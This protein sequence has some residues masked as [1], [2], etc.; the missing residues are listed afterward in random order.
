MDIFAKHRLTVLVIIVLIV[1][2]LMS[3]GSLWYVHV[4][5]PALPPP[6]KISNDER[7]AVPYFFKKEM[8][9]SAKQ[10]SAIRASRKNHFQEMKSLDNDIRGLKARLIA[11]IFDDNPEQSVIDSLSEKIGRKE[12]FRERMIA[13][14]LVEI[15]SLLNDRQKVRMRRLMRQMIERVQPHHSGRSGEFYNRPFR[16]P[17]FRAVDSLR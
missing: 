5:R 13:R 7:D 2:N 3:L 14:H 6:A 9:L 11:Q 17:R 4:S 10:M 12:G 15:R 16:P 8:G 1:L